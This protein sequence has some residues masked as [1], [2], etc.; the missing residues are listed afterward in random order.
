MVVKSLVLKGPRVPLVILSLCPAAELSS[1]ATAT[2]TGA[3]ESTDTYS[4]RLG[5]TDRVLTNTLR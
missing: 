5:L 2:S 4:M 3:S 1:L